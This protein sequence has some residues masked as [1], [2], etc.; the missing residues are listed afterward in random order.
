MLLILNDRE[1][2]SILSEKEKNL[3]IFA[4]FRHGSQFLKVRICSSRSKFLPLRVDLISES[5]IIQRS[6]QE[7]MQLN[8]IFFSKEW[9]GAFVRAWAF[10]RINTV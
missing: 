6:K 7:F 8:K 10:I 9:Q 4:S 5:Y 1:V 2:M 3:T